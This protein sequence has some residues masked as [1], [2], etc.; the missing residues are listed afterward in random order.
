MSCATGSAHT[1]TISDECVAYSF[2][3][4]RADFA[5]G[6]QLGLEHDE[7]SVAIPSRIPNLPNIQMVSC[8]QS[9]TT[10]VDYEGFLWSFGFNN[11]GQ[12]GTGNTTSF[13]VPQ[14]ILDIPPV[15]FVSCGST[16]T[17]IITCDTRLW[18]CGKNWNGQLFLGH[19]EKQNKFQQTSFSN[20]K[21][22][23][24]AL[25]YSILENDKEE[26]YVCGSNKLG[27]LGFYDSDS[28]IEPCL[29]RNKPPNIVQFCVGLYHTL[30]LD[31][32][33]TVF[34]SGWNLYGQLGIGNNIP[35]RHALNKILNIPPIKIISCGRNS[36]YLIDLDGNVWS[37]GCGNSGQLGLGHYKNINVP[38]QIPS[39]KEINQISQGASSYHVLLKNSQNE[40]LVMGNNELGQIT[41][42]TDHKQVATPVEIDP[43]FSTIWRNLTGSRAKSARK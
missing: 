41:L 35:P 26:I 4:N 27:Q 37:F 22:I 18:S 38:T 7:K 28:Q 33:G 40:I 19:T 16:Y 6:G 13:N 15:Q 8:G 43:N 34:S 12:L 14:K 25:D 20:V 30:F 24:T 31:V 29:M 36:S 42:G 3:S 5:M 23:A 2:G 1:I 11:D 32:D 9:F 10:C 39:I 17:L 21:K